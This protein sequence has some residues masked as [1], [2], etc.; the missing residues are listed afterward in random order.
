MVKKKVEK[1]VERE[2]SEEKIES[3]SGTEFSS[4]K[5]K[6]DKPRFEIRI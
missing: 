3:V 1:K 6:E 4:K 5:K 2:M